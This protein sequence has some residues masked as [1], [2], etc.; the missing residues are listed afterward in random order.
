MYFVKKIHRF[1]GLPLAL[2]IWLYECCSDVD[3]EIALRIA[4]ENTRILNR[5]VICKQPTSAYLVETLFRKSVD[6]V[7]Y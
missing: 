5:E 6:K 4:N 1:G 3:P 2:Q 7:K